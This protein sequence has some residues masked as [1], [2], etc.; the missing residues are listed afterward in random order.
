ME[1][2]TAA[3]VGHAQWCGACCQ[4]VSP[5]LG[6]GSA[7]LPALVQTGYKAEKNRKESEHSAKNVKSGGFFPLFSLTKQWKFSILY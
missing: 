2:G 4:T 6:A 7:R 5:V 1:I 3:T